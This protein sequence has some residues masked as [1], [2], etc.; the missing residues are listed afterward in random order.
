[1]RKNLAVSAVSVILILTFVLT[2]VTMMTD[3]FVSF[4]TSISGKNFLPTTATSYTLAQLTSSELTEN[5]GVAVPGIGK[6]NLSINTNTDS[7]YTDISRD[8]KPGQVVENVAGFSLYNGLPWAADSNTYLYQIR[9]AYDDIYELYDKAGISYKK[10][11]T[12]Q[13]VNSKYG[14]TSYYTIDDVKCVPICTSPA[15][16]CKR[17]FK[18]YSMLQSSAPGDSKSKN[19]SY[20]LAIVLSPKSADIGDSSQ[21]LYLPASKVD[22]KAHTFYGGVV[23]TNVALRNPTTVEISLNWDGKVDKGTAKYFD[24]SSYNEASSML[25]DIEK[26]IESSRLVNFNMG[27]WA[28]S[29]L[30]TYNW[31]SDLLNLVN[32]S[33]SKYNIVGVVVWGDSL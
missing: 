25:R 32:S 27:S 29:Y 28:G 11:S 15:M 31:P 3:A 7:W 10:V 14:K 1:M 2:L 8:A 5:A 17:Y 24:I 23:Q 21:Y 4:S 13:V 19:G 26:E 6:S 20:K 12:A 30:E 22:A 16:I 33:A 18:D 9:N